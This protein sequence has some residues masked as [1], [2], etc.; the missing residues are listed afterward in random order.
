MPCFVQNLK[1]LIQEAGETQEGDSE[2]PSWYYI[3]NFMPENKNVKKLF[4]IIVG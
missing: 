1:E 3:F 4:H 2:N